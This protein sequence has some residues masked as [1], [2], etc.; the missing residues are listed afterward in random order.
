MLAPDLSFVLHTRNP[1]A[2][3]SGGAESDLYAELAPGMGET[4]AAGTEGS[5]WRL[6]ASPAVT[7]RAFA[8]F[9]QAYM[10]VSGSQ[11]LV[12]AGGNIYGSAAKEALDSGMV[13]QRVVAYSALPMSTN[14]AVREELGGKLYDIGRYLETSLKGSQDIEGAAVGK[15]IYI[16]QSRPQP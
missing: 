1:L 4:L 6:T 9:S 13:S 8:N 12:P 11:S 7:M 2:G 16:V 10:P 14:E 15:T 5:A 3:A